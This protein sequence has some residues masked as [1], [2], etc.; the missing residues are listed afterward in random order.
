VIRNKILP[1]IVLLI[2]LSSTVLG[3]S[4]YRIESDISIKNKTQG[5]QGSL[6]L[7]KVYYDRTLQK[8]VYSITFP[9]HE[10]WVIKDTLTYVFRENKLVEKNPVIPF[11]R[12]TVFHKCL[13]GTLNDFG[14]KGSVYQIDKVEKDGDMVITTWKPPSKLSQIGKIITSTVSNSLHGVVIM[15]PNEDI[16][17]KQIYKNYMVISGLKVPTEIIQIMYKDGSELYQVITLSNIQ[18]NNNSNE[19]MY[20]YTIDNQ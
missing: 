12:E 10:I 2:L 11:T 1:G 20:N 16:L 13:E 8:L 6:T 4:F 15:N 17:S 5:G 3:Q 18:I 19:N 14:L 9:E 7:G